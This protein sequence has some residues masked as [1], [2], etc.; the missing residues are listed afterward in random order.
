MPIFF[1]THWV[2]NEKHEQFYLIFFT[3]LYTP[4]IIIFFSPLMY[5]FSD[6]PEWEFLLNSR[7]T[8]LKHTR[9]TKKTRLTWEIY[10][11][12]RKLSNFG[13]CLMLWYHKLIEIFIINIISSIY[14]AA[15]ALSTKSCEFLLYLLYFFTIIFTN[16][17]LYFFELPLNFILFFANEKY[18]WNFFL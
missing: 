17:F 2:E 16:F 9:N 18:L 10:S 12:L 5:I 4:K 13:L 6:T 15:R 8:L 11:N 3:L 1:L 7:E 14:Y